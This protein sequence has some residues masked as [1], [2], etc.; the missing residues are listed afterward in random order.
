MKPFASQG[1]TAEPPFLIQSFAACDDPVPRHDLMHE[2]HVAGHERADLVALEQH[3][4]RVARLHQPRHALRAAGAREEPDLDLRQADA[5]RV[6]IREDAVMAGERQLEGA[7]EA[8]AVHRRRERL[9]AGLEPPVEQRQ[10]ARFL[11]EE[12]H[13]GLLAALLARAWRIRRRAP[14]AW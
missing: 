2:A 7:A 12:A 9:A 5:G 13:G 4:Q 14:A 6:G 1:A 8:D 11:E 10:P 3:L